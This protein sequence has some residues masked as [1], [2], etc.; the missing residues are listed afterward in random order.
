MQRMGDGLYELVMGVVNR[1]R[2]LY[3]DGVFSVNMDW[4][5]RHAVLVEAYRDEVYIVA[6]NGL[7]LLV[8]LGKRPHYIVSRIGGD[9]CAED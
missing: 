2:G 5:L 9:R 6:D 1:F 7:Y 8:R 4:W 3:R